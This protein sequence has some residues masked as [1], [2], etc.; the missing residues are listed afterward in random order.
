MEIKAWMME[1]KVKLISMGVSS[2]I[3]NLESKVFIVHR[4]FCT[5]S[6]RIRDFFLQTLLQTPFSKQL[7]SLWHLLWTWLRSNLVFHPMFLRPLLHKTLFVAGREKSLILSMIHPKTFSF[8]SIH[9]KRNSKSWLR[10]SEPWLLSNYT[11]IR[12][13]L[14]IFR[15]IPTALV[16]H[17]LMRGSFQ[18]PE[19][20]FHR[21]ITSS[22]DEVSFSETS[23]NVS[24]EKRFLFNNIVS[25]T[26]TTY[27]FLTTTVTKTVNI[28]SDG[29]GLCRP[30]GYVVCV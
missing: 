6:N 8:L 18:L 3:L 30:V 10:T 20:T 14:C 15:L 13:W 17:A 23:P 19:Q 25:T 29:E 9:R 12:K 5:S 2:K 11:V 1:W 21:E 24:K 26:V 28:A 16:P 27:T 4:R 22:K 7:H